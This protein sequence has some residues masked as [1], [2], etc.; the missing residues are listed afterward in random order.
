[1]PIEEK[2]KKKKKG[3][4]GGLFKSSK[5][6]RSVLANDRSYTNELQKS[7]SKSPTREENGVANGA[8]VAEVSRPRPLAEVAIVDDRRRG[9]SD[10]SQS[11]SRKKRV[12]PQPP[13]PATAAVAGSGRHS[14]RNSDSSSGYHESCASPTEDR[15]SS[16]EK[17]AVDAGS[18][19]KK[20]SRAP[21]P[22]PSA[23][24]A[25]QGERCL[26]SVGRIAVA[27][28]RDAAQAMLT[29]RAPL[30]STRQ[31]P[32]HERRVQV[33]FRPRAK[34][35]LVALARPLLVPFIGLT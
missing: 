28:W 6:V 29:K 23:Q 20:K 10:L 19:G 3:F 18:G 1:M 33:R 27:H 22:P 12:A 24:R 2:Q 21:S 11:S 34:T 17:S 31:C 4:F 14:R 9:E 25:Q 30:A 15:S 13:E 32:T 7:K 8:V 16:L 26:L 35:R 5:V